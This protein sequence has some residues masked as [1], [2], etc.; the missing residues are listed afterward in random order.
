MTSRSALAV[1]GAVGLVSSIAALSVLLLMSIDTAARDLDRAAA[2]QIQCASAMAVRDAL[3]AG[4]PVALRASVERYHRS[5]EAEDALR[6]P[7]E[8]AERNQEKAEAHELS[9]AVAADKRARV[10]AL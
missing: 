4:D 2:S 1:V 5:V 9:E 7:T 10:D 6:S 8:E 3:M